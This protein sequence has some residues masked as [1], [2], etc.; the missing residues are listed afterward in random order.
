MNRLTALLYDRFLMG[1]PQEAGLHELR[2]RALAPARGEVLEVGA[3]TGLNL[4]AYPREGITRLVCTEPSHAMA[5]QIEAKASQAPVPPEVVE[6]PA[7]RLPFPDA[8]FDT[9]TGTLV[10]CEVPDQAAALAEIARVLRPGGSFC[11]LEHV[12]SDE[13]GLARR[14]DRWA[15]AWRALSGGCNCNRATL[16]AIEASPLGVAEVQ[17]ERFPK[18]PSIVRPVILGRASLAAA[19]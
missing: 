6:A 10:F 5:R 16:G 1:A 19:G 9:V 8:S 7:A 4:S 18:A 11:F 15:P 14:Q 2:E 17:A 13:P 12:R 3:G